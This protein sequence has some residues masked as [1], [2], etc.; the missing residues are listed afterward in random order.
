M[1]R[2]ASGLVRAVRDHQRRQLYRLPAGRDGRLNA[3]YGV[4]CSCGW[5][6]HALGRP[7]AITAY[8][9]HLL[10]TVARD[11]ESA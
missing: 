9:R 2:R 4:G 10:T 1:G 6:Q 8:Q 11:Q 3:W 5:S 7:A